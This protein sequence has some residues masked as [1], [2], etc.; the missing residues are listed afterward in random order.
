M[1]WSS[2]VILMIEITLDKSFLSTGHLACAN[3]SQI[4]MANDFRVMSF[5]AKIITKNHSAFKFQTQTKNVE[6][7]LTFNHI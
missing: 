5:V 2:F 4:W 7:D 1:V 3:I 6:N